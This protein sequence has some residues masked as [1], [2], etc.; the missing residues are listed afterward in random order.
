MRELYLGVGATVHDPAL[1][2]MDDEGNLLYAEALERPLQHK[3]AWDICP[4]SLFDYLTARIW[5][6]HDRS[7]HWSI[8]LSWEFDSK[9]SIQNRRKPETAPLPGSSSILKFYGFPDQSWNQWL[10]QMQ[11]HYLSRLKDTLP[12][13]I[14]SI[15]GQVKVELYS[16][17]HH[18]THAANAFY[19][20]DQDNPAL[21]MVVDG[22][23]E[24]GSLSVFS[25]EQGC[26]KRIARSWGPGS[27]GGFYGTATNL[28]GFDFK[29]G[30]EWKLMGLAAYGQ[31]NESD[32]R[33]LDR[34]I[35][36]KNGKLLPI[37][38]GVYE[39]VVSRYL[40]KI[41]DFKK[42]PLLAKDLA[43]TAQSIFE[44]RMIEI[45]NHY[46][47]RPAYESLLLSGGCALNSK[48]NGEI[49][50]KTAFKQVFIP[51]APGDDGNAVGAACLLHALK[52]PDAPRFRACWQSPYLGSAINLKPLHR[53]LGNPCGLLSYKFG[54][55]IYRETAKRL[56]EG[57]LIAWVQGNSE[58]GPRALGNRSILAN[59]QIPDIK[60]ILNNRVKFRE[61]YR[62]FAPAILHEHGTEWFE[63]Y[64]DSPYMS[65]TLK[66]KAHKKQLVPGVV[67][68]DGT[69]RVQSVTEE[70]NAQFHRL[71][72]EF[73]KISELP[74][75]LNTSLNVM[76]KPIVSSFEDA[77]CVFLTTGLDIL[78]VGDV[79]I[80][81]P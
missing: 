12:F 52:K 37:D 66:W 6:F 47:Q 20:Y 30:E 35:G 54:A 63:S 10:L 16:F 42:N 43:H 48:L 22:E 14:E 55:Q 45:L 62:P 53:F 19:F 49:I 11:G 40:A 39:Q 46:Q 8:A 15:T 34:L 71:I 41:E 26:L 77:L 78:V 65:K 23:G 80:E 67:H 79:L 69:G 75:L 64:Q 7:T 4:T 59:P 36:C 3:I 73:Q 76:G 31:V 61:D 5:Q 56:F 72:L 70:R 25:A 38:P 33:E 81:K 51:P 74:I 13:V 60:N 1:A 24:V 50:E 57:K 18:S 44:E 9:R 32:Y 29:K 58:F 21:C 27:F 68:A 17:D 2:I 28:C